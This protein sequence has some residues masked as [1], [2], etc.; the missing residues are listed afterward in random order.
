MN[1]KVLLLSVAVIAVGLFAMPSTLSLFSGQHT[2]YNGSEVSCA[3]C[4]ADIYN[5]LTVGAGNQVHTSGS[6]K[7]CEGCHRT[8]SSSLTADLIPYNATLNLSA[9]GGNWSG[10]NVTTNA[11]AHAAVTMECIGCHSGVPDELLGSEAAHGDFYNASN[12]STGV[13]QTQ[14]NLKGA[15]TACIGC[16]T[17]AIVNITW[18]RATG[19]NMTANSSGGSWNMTFELNTSNTD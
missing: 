4:H 2:F 8:N 16:H 12:Y 17:H 5:E 3:K 11:N 19:Y 7:A 9:G 15:N 14:I 6:L 10:T 1:S 18:T 13:N